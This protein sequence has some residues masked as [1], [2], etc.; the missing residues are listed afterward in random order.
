MK[1]L[2]KDFLLI[3]LMLSPVLYAYIIWDDVPA[4]IPVHWNVHGEIDQYG[5]KSGLG[6]MLFILPFFTYLSMLVIPFLDPK[7]KLHMMGEK[8]NAL[9]WILTLMM[10]AISVI[11]FYAAVNGL[12]NI[13]MYLLSGSGVLF[14]LM[15]NY[16]RTLRPNYF[17]GIRTPWTL[18]SDKVWKETHKLSGKVW[19]VGGLLQALT[20]FIP[21]DNMRTVITILVFSVIILVPVVYSFMLHKKEINTPSTFE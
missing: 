2:K 13:G 4:E 5:S 1:T 18:E 3:L 8:Y 11:I 9:K 17:I 14:M 10:S 21:N 15:G 19:V 20:I 6:I 16:F 7:K 12:N